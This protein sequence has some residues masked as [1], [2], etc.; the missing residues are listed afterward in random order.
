MIKKQIIIFISFVLILATGILNVRGQEK[1]IEL[2]DKRITIQMTK[3]PL[4]DVFMQLIYEYDVAIGFE[5]SILDRDHNYYHFETNIPYDEPITTAPNGS[6]IIKSGGKPIVENHLITINYKDARLED[7]MN[8]IVKQMKNYDWVI[9]DDVINVF[10]VR[11]RN[12]IFEKLLDLRIREF[13]LSEG[14]EVGKIQPLIILFLPEFKAFLAENDLHADASKTA[15]WFDER[16]LPVGMKFSTLTFKELLN[17][18]T[19]SKRGGWIL[20]RSKP[21]KIKD[22]DSIDVLI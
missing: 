16:P 4:F 2:K 13:A 17:K 11:G 14:A 18:I 9:N 3:K 8:D 12:K 6:R 1:R 7:V 20:R 22:K 10:P 19:K 21:N 15:P 5:E